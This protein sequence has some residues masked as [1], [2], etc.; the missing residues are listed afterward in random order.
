MG[1]YRGI[2]DVSYLYVKYHVLSVLQPKNCSILHL[3]VL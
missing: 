2:L 1:V 3:D